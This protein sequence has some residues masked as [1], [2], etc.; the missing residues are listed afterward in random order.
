MLSHLPCTLHGGLSLGDGFCIGV[1]VCCKYLYNRADVCTLSATFGSHVI[2]TECFVRA[3]RKF[4]TSTFEHFSLRCATSLHVPV[5]VSGKPACLPVLHPWGP[6]EAE[7]E[8]TKPG[9]NY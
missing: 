8:V 5:A 4:V 2:S 7:Y 1:A 6:F 3:L 9:T